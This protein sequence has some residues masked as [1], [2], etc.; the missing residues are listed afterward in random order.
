VGFGVKL[1]QVSGEPAAL[2]GRQFAKDEEG[3]GGLNVK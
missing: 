2:E 1:L 3:S